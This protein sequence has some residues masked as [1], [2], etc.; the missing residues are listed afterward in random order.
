MRGSLRRA[1]GLCIGIVLFVGV[2]GV[3]PS[4]ASAFELSPKVVDDLLRAADDFHPRP[5][6]LPQVELPANV[7]KFGAADAATAELLEED[8]VAED[9]TVDEEAED[10]SPDEGDQARI[11]ECAEKGLIAII[12][13]GGKGL[14]Y[15]EAAEKGLAHCFDEFVP[16]GEE[17]RALVDYFKKQEAEQSSKAYSDSHGEPVV[18]GNWLKSTAATFH[19]VATPAPPPIPPDSKS[20]VSPG[21]IVLIIGL[22]ALLFFGYRATQRKDRP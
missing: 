7:A 21:L 11:K 9:T 4:A 3:L 12:E 2:I 18:L 19:P 5:L 6:E 8:Q 14:T 16:E 17:V 1:V 15:E 10:V 13:E 22:A 20:G